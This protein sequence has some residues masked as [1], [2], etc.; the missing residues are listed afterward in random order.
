MVEAAEDDAASARTGSTSSGSSRTSSP[1]APTRA[2]TARRPATGAAAPPVKRVDDRQRR[3]GDESEREFA[4][5]TPRKRRA[6]LYED[7]TIDTQPSVHRHL[8]R[9]WPVS[10]EDG[11]GTWDDGSTALRC[12]RLVRRSAIPASSGSGPSTSSATRSEQQIEGAMRA[13]AEEGLLADFAPEWVEF[14]RDGAADPGV[15]RARPVVR[16][17]RRSP[18]TACRTASPPASACRRR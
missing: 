15:R 11:R 7:V 3:P 16:D 9:G 10:F 13:A 8:T 12:E 6:T 17:R 14:L 4:W 5:F 18:A 1:P 2:A